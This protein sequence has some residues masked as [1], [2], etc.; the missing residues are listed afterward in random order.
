[1]KME[2]NQSF[3]WLIGTFFI[4]MLGLLLPIISA[5]VNLTI[6]PSNT[7]T[8]FSSP[9]LISCSASITNENLT[10]INI[11]NNN[12]GSWV[13]L[14][15]NTTNSFPLSNILIND[16]TANS[17]NTTCPYTAL[18]KTFNIYDYVQ[19]GQNDLASSYQGHTINVTYSFNY[20]DSTQSNVSQISS[21]TGAFT[22]YNYTN[23]NL[24]KKVNNI[25]VFANYDCNIGISAIPTEKNDLVIGGFTLNTLLNLSFGTNY[26]GCSACDNNSNCYYTN[27]TLNPTLLVNSISYNSSTISGNVENYTLNFNLAETLNSI[28]F[29]YNNT[30]YPTYLVNTGSSYIATTTLNVPAVLLQTNKSFYW[31]LNL[32]S[33]QYNTT[34][35]NQTISTFNIDNCSTYTNKIFNLTL[36]DEQTQL[37]IPNGTA[38]NGTIQVTV[39]LYP[40][41][42]YG[43]PSYVI[44]TISKQFTNTNNASICISP[45]NSSSYYMDSQIRYSASN[46]VTKQYNIQKYLLNNSTLYQNITLY[47]LLSSANTNF[48]ITIKDASFLPLDNTLIIIQR[49]YINDGNYQTVEIPLSDYSGTAIGH[50]DLNSVSYTISLVKDGETV[51]TF[52]NIMPICINPNIEICQLNLNVPSASRGFGDFYYIGNV[53]YNLTYNYTNKIITLQFNTRDGTT[54]TL[55]LNATDNILGNSYCSNSLTSSA[56]SFTCNISSLTN[57][58][59]L[60]TIYEGTTQIGNSLFVV[61]QRP[62]DIFGMDSLIYAF[63]FLVTICMIFITDPVGILIAFVVGIIILAVL[64]IFVV[65]SFLGVTSSIIWLIV[66]VVIIIYKLSQRRREGI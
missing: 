20:N 19:R 58:T 17:P 9:E 47:N 26:L 52:N 32:E 16:T 28:S 25:N 14:G 53:A 45:I 12:T 64:N 1:M 4:L 34:S 56:G 5:T 29:Y 41:N 24:L 46:Y 7:T 65:S 11:Y 60:A 39:T 37:M 54:T 21:G 22:T 3:K 59:V 40:L 13:S 38:G 6:I 23:P 57:A 43:N 2:K 33:G 50:F 61:S 48:Q 36:K 63:I 8:Q 18:V 31:V 66:A 44:G 30:I 15:N 49:Q 55:N 35:L 10:S 62:V 27:S 42:Q 51:A